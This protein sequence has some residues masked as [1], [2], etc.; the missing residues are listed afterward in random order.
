MLGRIPIQWGSSSAGRAPR[1]QC[2]GQGFDPPLLHHQSRS[3]AS[4]LAFFLPEAR[5]C[6]GLRGVMQCPADTRQR[7]SRARPHGLASLFL[8]SAGG[9]PGRRWL[10]NQRVVRCGSR[11]TPGTGT[12]SNGCSAV[13]PPEERRLIAPGRRHLV[14]LQP[15]QAER[16]RLLAGQQALHHGRRQQRQPQQLVDRGRVQPL[17]PRDLAAAGDATR[18]QQSGVAAYVRS[19]GSRV[20]TSASYESALWYWCFKVKSALIES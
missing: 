13:H 16:A 15:D 14:V 20:S 9:C 18:V 6:A 1:S 5:V 3:Q 8:H 7:H 11:S 2:G 4:R 10:A 19:R 12:A 17:A